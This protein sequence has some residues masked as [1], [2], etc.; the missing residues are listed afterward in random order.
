MNRDTVPPYISIEMNHLSGDKDIERLHNLGYRR[1]KIIDQVTFA[2]PGILVTTLAYA[3]P[4]R[5]SNSLRRK[6]K[7]LLGVGS[8]D[9]WVFQ[10]GT[11]GAFGEDTAGGWHSVDWA[12][13]RWKYLHNIDR[14]Y[15]ARSLTSW[16]DIHAAKT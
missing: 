9:N 4:K 14:R 3:L 15:A 2:Q 12:R 6:V 13:R 16:F 10:A 8:V 5:W 7:R 11:S 1:F